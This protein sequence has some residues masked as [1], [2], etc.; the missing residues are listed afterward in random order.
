M[1]ISLRPQTGPSLP[2]TRR[3]EMTPPSGNGDGGEHPRQAA[4][5]RAFDQA[6]VPDLDEVEIEPEDEDVADV[7]LERV[8]Q[9]EQRESRRPHQAGDD[10]AVGLA[11]RSRTPRP[12][13]AASWRPR[14][15][16]GRGARRRRSRGAG[17]ADA[18]IAA[19]HPHGTITAVM[20]GGAIAEPES[21]GPDD[22]AVG[23]AER[24][25]R[26]SN[27]T[28]LRAR[29]DTWGRPA[30]PSRSGAPR[31]GR[32]RRA[33]SRRRRPAGTAA[34]RTVTATQP[35]ASTDSVRF[36]PHVSASRP[37]GSM[38]QRVAGEER[39][40]DPAHLR[41]REPVLLHDQGAGDRDV[42]AAEIRRRGR[43][44]EQQHQSPVRAGDRNAGHRGYSSAGAPLSGAAVVW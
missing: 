25:R 40:E 23:A 10:P 29:P 20:K 7:A 9:G 15:A 38:Q 41:L 18:T 4:D 12:D 3:S 44:G 22:E 11:S 34:W 13:P 33:S 28:R 42:H 31:A 43:R 6:E 8:A 39:A 37:P 5:E 27:A 35:H 17:M 2:V 36:A 24:G 19:R 1:G 26:G 16:P 32:R 21:D 14:R 30:R